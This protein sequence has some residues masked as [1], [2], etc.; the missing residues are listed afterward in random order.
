[1]SLDAYLQSILREAAEALDA[2]NGSVVLRDET[3]DQLTLRAV[4]TRGEETANSQVSFSNSLAERA[5]GQG[6]S[7]LCQETGQDPNSDRGS[8]GDRRAII[9]A[10]LRSPRKKLGVLHLER[11]GH[12]EP[13][14]QNDLHLA[15][16]LASSVSATL[17]SL[18]HLL[19]K[20]QALLIQTLTT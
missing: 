5:L 14:D 17:E 10:L 6:E 3:T 4:Y 18:A 9:C 2:R 7:L 16:A 20:E 13:F 1:A 15:D 11:G 12:D 19:E 8:P